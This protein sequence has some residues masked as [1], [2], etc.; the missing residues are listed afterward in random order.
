MRHLIHPATKKIVNYC[1]KPSIIT[2]IFVDIKGIR[3]D[4]NIGK[5]N[6]Q[7]LLQLPFYEIYHQLEYKLKLIGI[8]L[9]KK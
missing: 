9:V 5:V 3:A 1:I 8:N 7:K 6:N 2:V 4:N